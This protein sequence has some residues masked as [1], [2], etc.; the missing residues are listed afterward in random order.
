MVSHLVAFATATAAAL[1]PLDCQV[2][3]GGEPAAAASQPVFTGLGE[4]TA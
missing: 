1:A 2:P 3:F 4:D